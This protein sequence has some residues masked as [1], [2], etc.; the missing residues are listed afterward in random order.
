MEQ[1]KLQGGS[2]AKELTPKEKR[3]KARE[4][5]KR[6]VAR[7]EAKEANFYRLL[8]F[9]MV[10][11]AIFAVFIFL[12]VSGLF[13]ILLYWLNEGANLIAGVAGSGYHENAA[14]ITYPE[15]VI[16]YGLLFA[17]MAVLGYVAR[18]RLL[19]K[20]TE[21]EQKKKLRKKKSK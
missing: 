13:D 8:T 6:L 20:V 21:R 9:D 7:M 15:N 11:C 1:E 3:Q 12:C 19:K 14:T 16:W 10:I 4:E 5:R 2:A 17:A 18:S